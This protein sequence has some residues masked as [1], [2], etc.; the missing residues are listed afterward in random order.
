[1]GAAAAQARNPASGTILVAVGRI[2]EAEALMPLHILTSL[3]VWRPR[4]R[5][6]KRLKKSI[7]ARL[8]KSLSR[9]RQS[10]RWVKTLRRLPVR[11]SMICLVSETMP[12]RKNRWRR[13]WTRL[14]WGCSLRR[15]QI[16]LPMTFLTSSKL[17]LTPMKRMTQNGLL[18]KGEC[19]LAKSYSRHSRGKV[20]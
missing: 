19:F 16:Q 17:N 9:T 18:L 10:C 2:R 3:V 4:T 12:L 7:T 5:P 20:S 6:R 11:N 15:R 1:M 13:S 8:R 14:S